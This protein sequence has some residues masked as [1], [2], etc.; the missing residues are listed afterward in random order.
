MLT[1]LGPL[2]VAAQL[3]GSLANATPLRTPAVTEFKSRV[4]NDAVLRFVKDS[5]ICETTPGVSQVSGYLD[6]GT[7]MSMWFWFFEAR[8]NPQKAPF[9]LW[10]NGLEYAARRR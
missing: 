4:H 2:L 6:I 5:G 8:H 10:I 9:T 3:L 7:N 1:Y